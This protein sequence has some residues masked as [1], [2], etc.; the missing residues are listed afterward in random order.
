VVFAVGF[1]AFVRRAP[2]AAT[3]S[4]LAF[5]AVALMGLV[6]ALLSPLDRLADQWFTAHMLQHMLLVMLAAPA[7]LLA[8]PFPVMLWALPGPVRRRFGRRLTRASVLG[9]LW[10]AATAMVLTWPLYTAVLWLWHLPAAYDAAVAHRWLHDLEHLTFFT[11]AVLFWSPVIRPAPRFRP[12]AP[13]ALRIV[14]L[15]LAAF[16]TAAL[17]VVLTL[18]PTVLYRSYRTLDDQA[19]GG[20]LMWGLGGLI[21]MLAVLVVLYRSLGSGA[22]LRPVERGAIP[23]REVGGGVVRALKEVE[24]GGVE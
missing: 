18:A 13:P 1:W 10:A 21:D 15:V 5:A 11:A 9:R 3:A 17:G 7:L 6:T 12:A 2:T 19:A 16:Q 22:A 23:A 4:R 14:Y 24:H 8:D 20:I